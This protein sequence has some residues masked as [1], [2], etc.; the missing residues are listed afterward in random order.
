MCDLTRIAKKER[1]MVVVVS[2]RSV[3][4]EGLRVPRIPS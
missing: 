4:R 3:S 2:Q 1:G